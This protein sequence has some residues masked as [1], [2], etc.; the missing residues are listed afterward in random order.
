MTVDGRRRDG[1]VLLA[2]VVMGLFAVGLL[3]DS[4]TKQTT[5]AKPPSII[6]APPQGG[7]LPPDPGIEDTFDRGDSPLSLGSTAT[8]AQWQ[9]IG[10]VWGVNQGQAYVAVPEKS[11]AM[12]TLRGGTADGRVAVSAAKMAPGFGLVFRCQSVLNCWRV[13]AVP[14]FGTWNVIKVENGTETI[15][16]RLGTVSVADDTEIAVEM[17]GSVLTFFIDGERVTAIDDATFKD[18]DG[19][20]ISLREPASAGVARWSNFAVTVV[21]GAGIVD[22]AE[23]TFYDTFDRADGDVMGEPW[24]PIKGTWAVKAK[25]AQ[26]TESVTLGANLALVDGASSDG[27]VQATIYR[28]QQAMG[29]A[30]RCKDANNCWRVEAA[31]GFGTWNVFRVVNGTVTK[32]GTLGI[33]P[34]SAGT[35]V[36]VQL[37]GNKAIAYINGV[38]ALKFDVDE[39]QSETGAGLVVETDPLATTAKWSEFVL[40]P[41]GARL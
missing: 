7:D 24:N 38:E 9:A 15:A 33:Q 1:A 5:V 11:V 23:A 19:A 13:E 30:F 28:P 26:V 20:G 10:G 31:I 8:G 36:S 41:I 2:M 34:T 27:I 22:V 32:V 29:I 35:T 16:A 25:H 37:A 14:Q 21:K 17:N 3:L 6:T 39:L 18:D 12:A 4:V 40:A